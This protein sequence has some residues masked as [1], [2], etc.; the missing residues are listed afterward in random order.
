MLKRFIIG[1]LV[2]IL[3]GAS[4]YEIIFNLVMSFATENLS[5]DEKKGRVKTALKS[6]KIDISNS[7]INLAIELAVAQLK[8]KGN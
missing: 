3:V 2:N 7:L 6:L 5:G 8:L 4:I 1:K